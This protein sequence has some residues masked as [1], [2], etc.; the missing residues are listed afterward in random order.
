MMIHGCS[1]I[2]LIACKSLKLKIWG[3]LAK[4]KWRPVMAHSLTSIVA[5]AFL[6][7]YLASHNILKLHQRKTRCLPSLPL[8]TLLALSCWSRPSISIGN[9]W[10]I[11][12]LTRPLRS[13]PLSLPRASAVPPPQKEETDDKSPSWPSRRWPRSWQRQA[14]NHRREVLWL[15]PRRRR[16]QWCSWDRRVCLWLGSRSGNKKR[17]IGFSTTRG[18]R[19]GDLPA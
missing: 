16:W 11:L 10:K 9:H 15:R 8:I 2:H 1:L 4:G 17:D 13:L 19:K 12:E 7:Y 5:I 3:N 18:C 6:Q 14:K